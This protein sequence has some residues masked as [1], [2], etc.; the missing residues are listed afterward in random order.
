MESLNKMINGIKKLINHL[1][2]LVVLVKNRDI[3]EV[4]E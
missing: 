1:W 3:S 4:L 2:M